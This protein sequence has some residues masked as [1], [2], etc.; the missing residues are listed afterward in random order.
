MS[1]VTIGDDVTVWVV[2][3]GGGRDR[4]APMLLTLYGA[5]G[6]PFADPD[7][8]PTHLAMATH[9]GWS[10]AYASVR[11]GGERGRA[12]HAAGRGERRGAALADAHS[13][14][15]WA[16]AASGGRVALVTESAGALL[17]GALIAHR[18]GDVAAAVLKA[19]CVDLTEQDALSAGEDGEF[20]PSGA[21]LLSLAAVSPLHMLAQPSA[22]A[23]AAACR[24]PP[25]LI[26]VSRHDAARACTHCCA[27][28]CRPAVG[29]GPGRGA[30]RVPRV[31]GRVARD[32]RW[33]GGAR[34]GRPGGGVVCGGCGGEVVIFCS[35]SQHSHTKIHPSDSLTL[36]PWALPPPRRATPA[37]PPPGHRPPRAT[38]RSPSW[39]A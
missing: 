1:T 9:H 23:A 15:D 30:R 39:A 20:A 29:P 11:G 17:V 6:A 24:G 18:P 31:P 8:H 19:P 10:L 13:V 26:Q 12:W 16:V 4:Q 27:L 35:L 21:P 28:V 2:K 37:P 3:G 7:F 14:L 38:R 25:V 33:R 36:T 32:P 34:P 5:Y 22:Q